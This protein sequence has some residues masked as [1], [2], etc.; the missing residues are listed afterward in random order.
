MDRSAPLP[1]GL[2]GEEEGAELGD[3]PLPALDGL[4]A[5]SSAP[6]PTQLPEAQPPAGTPA[7]SEAHKERLSSPL[8]EAAAGA[9]AP[10]AADSSADG[11]HEE[12]PALEAVVT[13]APAAAAPLVSEALG[14][15]ANGHVDEGSWP[16][17]PAWA[18]AGSPDEPAVP[19]C[20][21][22]QLAA[23][24][25]D[26]A[27]GWEGTTSPAWHAA[28]HSD[29]FVAWEGVAWGG[30]IEN[31]S[32]QHAEPAADEAAAGQEPLQ[33]SSEDGPLFA[34][35]EAGAQRASGKTDL[36]QETPSSLAQ[37]DSASA[38][39]G[40]MPS[41]NNCS[42]EASE[43][44]SELGACSASAG[45]NPG[46]AQ[47]G[48]AAVERERPGERYWAAWVQLLQVCSPP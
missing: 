3:V 40:H 29:G 24:T 42:L 32:M 18:D 22:S 47:M 45:G 44:A 21:P 39:S 34:S 14:A 43:E 17:T 4:P 46:E 19:A 48:T 36:P 30:A 33:P 23:S 15:P 6:W 25:V 2:F 16:N 13:C 37:P 1:L 5:W 10:A 12:R 27:N 7:G 35:A 20:A 9:G 41:R 38:G 11:A 26:A 8:Q 31:G 28:D